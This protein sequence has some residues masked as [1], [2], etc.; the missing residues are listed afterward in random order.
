MIPA[1]VPLFVPWDQRRDQIMTEAKKTV[2]KP[3]DRKPKAGE[4]IVDGI[5]VKVSSES[6]DDFELLDDF[7]QMQNGNGARVTS[8]FHRMFGDDASR[9]LDEL[10]EESGRVRLTTASKFMMSV[11]K[12]LA[13]SS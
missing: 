1:L 11:M 3:Q 12:E 13:P 2:K 6:L 4:A 7:S 10:R 5:V 9:I 8:A